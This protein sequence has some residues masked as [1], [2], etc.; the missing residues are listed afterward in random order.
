[1]AS[2]NASFHEQ[3]VAGV[4]LA[5][6]KWACLSAALLLGLILAAW[7][8]DWVLVFQVWPDGIARLQGI[9]NRE[10]AWTYTVECWCGD[11]PKLARATANALYD[12]IFRVSGIH[13][14]GMRFANGDALSIPDTIVRNVYVGNYE[15]IQVAMVGTHLF[16]A[17]NIFSWYS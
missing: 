17:A 1:M 13:E 11:L 10:L 4:L 12:L 3:G 6:L 9:L 8:I 15:L 16:G 14:M 5:P 7:I 2:R